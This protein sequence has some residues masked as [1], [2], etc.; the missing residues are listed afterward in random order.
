MRLDLK[1]TNARIRT[2]DGA[3]STAH[4]LGVLNG[5]IVGLDQEVDALDAATSVDVGGATVVPGFNDVHAHSVWFGLGLVEVD[6]ATATDL[7]EVYR[8]IAAA[9]DSPPG[10]WIVAGGYNQH[11]HGGRFPDR[12]VLDAVGDGRPVWIKHTSGHAAIVNG[13]ALHLIGADR[14]APSVVGGRVVVDTSG[15]PTGLLEE[16][17][18]RLIQELALRYPVPAIEDAL[19]RATRQYAAEGITSVTDAGIG[20]GWIGNSPVEFTAYQNA[21]EDHRLHTRMQAM[22]A[23]DVLAEHTPAGLG[24]GIRSGVGNAWLQIGP[25]KIFTDGSLL[26]ATAYL[27]EN[28]PGCDHHG[29]LQDDPDRLR[30][31]ALQAAEAGWALAMHAIGDGAVDFALEVA[32]TVTARGWRAPMPHRIEHAGVVRPDQLDRLARSGVV[33][34]PQPYFIAEFGEGMRRNLGERVDWAYRAASLLERGIVVPG[35]S[36]RPVAP[37]SPLSVVQAF[38][39]RRTEIGDEFGPSERISC[40]QALH[41]YTRGSAAATGWAHCKGSLR[42]GMLA[43]FAILGDD[44]VAVDPAR[45]A[46]TEVVATILGGRFSHGDA[47]SFS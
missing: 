18:M 15:R 5:T 8:R 26:A 37:G 47:S 7:D 25:T 34:V 31:Q 17:A 44:P 43:D 20:G 33:P 27:S 4:S 24:A 35:S 46:D 14:V 23:I 12:D 42:P 41:A 1:V 3:R 36:D 22:I 19:E 38:V 29:Y 21:S 45:I 30:A 9:A 11:L 39:E 16:R 28:Y 10:S 6:L 13:V 2:M 32:E 40:E